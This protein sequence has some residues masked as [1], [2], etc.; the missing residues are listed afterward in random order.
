MTMNN[1][2]D[3]QH[4]GEIRREDLRGTWGM[5]RLAEG[6]TLSV[7]GGAWTAFLNSLR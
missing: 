2:Q 5:E 1:Q 6:F 4:E 3:G 7:P